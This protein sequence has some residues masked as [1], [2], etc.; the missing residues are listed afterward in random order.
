MRLL[1]FLLSIIYRIIIQFRNFLFDYQILKTEIYKTPVIC[2]GN[3]SIGGSGK[4]PHTIYIAKLLSPQYNVAILSR[5]YKRKSSGFN[6]VEIDS[7]VS[8]VGDEPLQIKRNNPNCIVAVSKN[9]KKGIEKI[10]NDHPKIN[11][12]L[13]DDGFQHRKIKAGLNILLTPFYNPFTKDKLLPIG[14]LREPASESIRADIIIISKSPSNLL[15]PEKMVVIEKLNLRTNQKGYVSSIIYHKYKCIKDDTVLKNEGDYNI[16]L[17]SGIENITPLINYLE[18]KE[19]K[20]NLI[21]FA[22]H[23]NY[24]AKDI[25]KILSIHN[26][27]KSTKKLILTTEKDATKLRAFMSD[28]KE[29]KVYYIPIEVTINGEETFK[30]QILEYVRNN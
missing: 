6:Y 18:E 14:T 12:I 17:V 21:K 3:I 26:K 8:Y 19:R 25:K 2:I 20:V 10:L 7:Y 22:D 13:L 27:D 1:L 11:I 28:F 5:G 30:Q 23:H 29:D 9:R 15:P 16:T 24:T 4:T